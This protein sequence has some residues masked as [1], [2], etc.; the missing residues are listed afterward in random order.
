MPIEIKEVI[1]KT[2]VEKEPHSSGDYELQ[3]KQLDD[4]K[5]EVLK[6]CEQMINKVIKNQNRR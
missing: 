4:L 2:S 1:I 3:V 5:K 6:S